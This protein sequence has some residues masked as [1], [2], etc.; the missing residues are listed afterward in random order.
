MSNDVLLVRA[1]IL[2]SGEVQGVYFRASARS[3]ARQHGLSGWVRNCVD[4]SVE[5]LV[6]GEQTAVQAFMVWCHDGP[7]AAHVT[8][9]RVSWE[10]FRGEFSDFVVRG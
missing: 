3:V 5:A 7:P 8:N 9:V 4:G 2:V 10:P 6:E 1:R